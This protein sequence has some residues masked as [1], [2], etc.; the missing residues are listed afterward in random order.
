MRCITY[1]LVEYALADE[2]GK[3]ELLLKLF[4]EMEVQKSFKRAFDEWNLTPLNDALDE[5][6]DWRNAGNEWNFVGNE[7]R[8][9]ILMCSE[10]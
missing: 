4:A 5:R 7:I 9:Q 6:L 2:A 8:E 10:K 1:A 3:S